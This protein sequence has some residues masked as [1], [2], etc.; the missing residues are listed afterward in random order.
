[1]RSK[2]LRWPWFRAGNQAP[3]LPQFVL[4]ADPAP[5]PEEA[6]PERR[7]TWPAE[8]LKICQDLWGPEFL[9]PGGADT[10]M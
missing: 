5:A 9:T 1:M 2:L 4:D 6:K 10:V 8:R 3:R 7:R